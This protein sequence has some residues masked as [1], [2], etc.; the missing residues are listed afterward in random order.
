[1]VF[2]KESAPARRAAFMKWYD[3]QTK[4][5]EG[6]SYDNP[7]ITSPELRSWYSDMIKTFPA[8]NGFNASQENDNSGVACYTIG[9]DVICVAFDSSVAKEAYQVVLDLAAKHSLG[10]FNVSG[11][12]SILIPEKGEMRGIDDPE[13]HYPPRESIFNP[14]GFILNFLGASVRW[15]YGT[16]WRTLSGKRRYK[17]TEYLYGPNYSDDWFDQKGHMFVNRIIGIVFVVV[18]FVILFKS[19]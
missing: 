19:C 11:D 13:D 7:A 2:R 16:I 17:F 1:M 4:W 5:S 9:R 3:D 14:D 18:L 6:H 8:M 10:L 12:E 15:T